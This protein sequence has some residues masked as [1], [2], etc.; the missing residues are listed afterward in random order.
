MMTRLD[1][2]IKLLFKL[3]DAAQEKFPER[4]F[5]EARAQTVILS[6]LLRLASAGME[7]WEVVAFYTDLIRQNL[8]LATD[9][10]KAEGYK[11]VLDAIDE[12][13]NPKLLN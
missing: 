6:Q 8:I 4:D 3:I 12:E 1:R 9:P 13:F 5:T 10:A 11:L 7:D 2:L